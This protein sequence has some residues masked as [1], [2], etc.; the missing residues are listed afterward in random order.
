MMTIL[1]VAVGALVLLYALYLGKD[2]KLS[3]SLL[4]TAAALEV[5]D[6][7]VRYNRDTPDA[8]PGLN[9]AVTRPRVRR[10]SASPPASSSR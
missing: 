5:T 1:M 3:L 6:R 9:E 2:V 4:G 8:T 7:R 10:S